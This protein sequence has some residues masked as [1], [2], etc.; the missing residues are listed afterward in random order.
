MLLPLPP[1]RLRLTLRVTPVH[2]RR[3]TL[4]QPKPLR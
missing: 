4:L 2:R 3:L 1:I